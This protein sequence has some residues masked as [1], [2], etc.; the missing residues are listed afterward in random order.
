MFWT[1]LV[2]PSITMALEQRVGQ[3]TGGKL[4]LELHFEQPGGVKLA[5]ERRFGQPGGGK[6]A[7]K[8]R[9]GRR[10][11]V[12]HGGVVVAPAAPEN[13]VKSPWPFPRSECPASNL[14]IDES[15]PFHIHQQWRF[16]DAAVW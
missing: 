10:R 9:L 3:P 7:L 11:H 16:A 5:L 4:T 1:L 13:E 6:L 14:L 2:E 8:R 12:G 15:A